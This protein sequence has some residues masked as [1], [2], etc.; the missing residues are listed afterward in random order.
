VKQIAKYRT[1]LQE[2]QNI[3]RNTAAPAA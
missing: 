3:L 2:Y 1:E